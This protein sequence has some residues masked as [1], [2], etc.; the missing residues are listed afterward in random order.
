[1]EMSQLL[2]GIVGGGIVA[3][4][5]YVFNRLNLKDNQVL[6]MR[7]TSVQELARIEGLFCEH[8][9]L[10]KYFHEN[11]EEFP[12]KDT[13]IQAIAISHNYMKIFAV[14]ILH[15]R[16]FPDIFSTWVDTTIK[17]RYKTSPI[18][19]ETMF[20]FKDEYSLTCLDQLKFIKEARNL[21]N[22]ENMNLTQISPPNELT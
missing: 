21:E 6:T 20:K 3:L 10:Y 4:I 8:P 12:D 7:Q 13:K 15:K 2:S 1:M 17:N 22:F 19:A 9:E 11:I 14:L 5:T 18:L 16:D